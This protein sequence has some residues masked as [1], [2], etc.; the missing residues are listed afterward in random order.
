MVLA[1][2]MPKD[3]LPG[4]NFRAEHDRVCRL[5][6]S[7][8]FCTTPGRNFAMRPASA[9]ALLWGV[10]RAASSLCTAS[11]LSEA[12]AA[13]SLLVTRIAEA[14]A[15]D[16]ATANLK[17][18]PLY[19]F[20]LE[21]G[22]ECQKLLGIALLPTTIVLASPCDGS[23][24]LMTWKDQ[25]LL[26]RPVLSK[27]SGWYS[28]VGVQPLPNPSTIA[29]LEVRLAV[30]PDRSAVQVPFTLLTSCQ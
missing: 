4:H 8:F 23:T 18:T 1:S 17:K 20:H 25:I 30:K 5:P 15:E 29:T 13:A 2:T 28:I 7:V 10:G 21:H 22:G 26:T 24:P 16:S 11:P 12:N 19:H 6:L 27:K 3:H 14:F 9:A